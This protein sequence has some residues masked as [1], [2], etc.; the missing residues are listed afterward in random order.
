LRVHFSCQRPHLF[1]Y[2]TYPSILCLRGVQ[3]PF[4]LEES[5]RNFEGSNSGGKETRDAVWNKGSFPTVPEERK[6]LA[7]KT[8]E[9]ENPLRPKGTEGTLRSLFAQNV[10]KERIH[11][12]PREIFVARS[13]ARDACSSWPGSQVLPPTTHS[14]EPCSSRQR[15]HRCLPWLLALTRLFSQSR[16]HGLRSHRC[17]SRAGSSTVLARSV[18]HAVRT[19]VAVIDL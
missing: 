5:H 4:G 3:A 17:S 7:H 19:Q 12:E 13:V 18:V 1:S 6:L 10:G 9:R 11:T 16:R 2:I 14:H 8:Q 15:R